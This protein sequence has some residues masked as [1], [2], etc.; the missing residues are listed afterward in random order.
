MQPRRRTR[1]KRFLIVSSLILVAALFLGLV[2]YWIGARQ[3]YAYKIKFHLE[4]IYVPEFRNEMGRWPAN[5]EEIREFLVRT[6][7]DSP[8]LPFWDELKPHIY[9]VATTNDQFTARLRFGFF[10]S[11]EYVLTVAHQP[12]STGNRTS[13]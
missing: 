2:A 5:I 11:K 12:G 7:P 8:M 13:P 9:D 1:R 3:A 10:G 6:N 4:M